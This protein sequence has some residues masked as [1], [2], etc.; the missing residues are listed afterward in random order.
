LPGKAER[1]V[2]LGVF[3]GTFDPVHIGHL[4]LAEVGLDRILFVPAAA[5]PHKP[6]GPV[7]SSGIRLEMLRAALDGHPRL[8]ATDLEL[9]RNGPSYTADTLAQIAG[10][11]RWRGAD[12][13]LLMGADMLLD[14]PRWSRPGEILSRASLL[15]AERTGSD[16]RGAEPDVLQ[17]TV[18]LRTPRIDISSSEIRR[19]IAEGKSVRYWVVEAVERIIRERRVYRA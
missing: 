13:V 16:A 12:L 10:E 2:R 15:A 17:R 19:R 3:G 14:L 5:P 8:E 11:P 18:F 6:G 7:A 4:I 1:A 9:R